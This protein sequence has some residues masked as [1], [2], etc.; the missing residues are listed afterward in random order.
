[1]S[2]EPETRERIQ[3]LIDGAPVLLFMKGNRSQPQ[4][5]FSAQV[6]AA[7]DSHG[8]EYETVDVLAD[9]ALREG[10]KAFSEWPTVPQLYVSGEFIGGCDIVTEMHESGELRHALERV[11]S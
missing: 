6:V 8:A 11:G 9:P 3:R 5:G 1:M 7:L 4:C 2:L 10:I